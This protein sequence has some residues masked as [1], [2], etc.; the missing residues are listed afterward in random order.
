MPRRLVLVA[1]V[2]ALGS[3]A[4]LHAA[5]IDP[6][7]GTWK[8]KSGGAGSLVIRETSSA[9]TFTGG[10]QGLTLGCVDVAAGESAGFAELPRQ[11]ALPAGQYD[12]TFGFPGQGCS[13]GVRLK[14]NL[15][16][17][18]GT[19]SFSEDSRTGGPFA[20]V[21]TSAVPKATKTYAWSAKTAHGASTRVTGSGHVSADASGALVLVQGTLSVALGSER[22]KLTVDPPGALKLGEKGTFTLT[23]AVNVVGGNCLDRTGKLVLTKG[24]AVISGVCAT[25]AV[26]TAGP[27]TLR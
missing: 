5:T 8:V 19:V 20:F 9:F 21:R 23:A 3:A 11:T 22:W 13:Y 25:P 18:A 2:A 17:L 27:T 14:L 1:A 10:P 4:A 26:S 7:I 24:H 6:L 15:N 16:S 12:A